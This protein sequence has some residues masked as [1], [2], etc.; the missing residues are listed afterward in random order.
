MSA[1][2]NNWLKGKLPNWGH[3]FAVVDFFHGGNFK[4][5][6]VEIINGKTTLW[7]EVIEG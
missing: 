5:E 1:E 7:G 4:I 3:A 2:N 6:I